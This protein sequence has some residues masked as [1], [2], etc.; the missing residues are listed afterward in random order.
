MTAALK[1]EKC[2]HSA[3]RCWIDCI[4]ELYC[5]VNLRSE[6]SAS[7]KAPP[8]HLK[9]SARSPGNY[10]MNR[11]VGMKR[12]RVAA[13]ALVFPIITGLAGIVLS[14]KSVVVFD[15]CL[16]VPKFS[17]MLCETVTSGLQQYT[18]SACTT[19]SITPAHTRFQCDA[20]IFYY[21]RQGRHL[22]VQ[23]RVPRHGCVRQE[24]GL[25]ANL[26]YESRFRRLSVSACAAASCILPFGARVT[27][28]A[29]R[30][31]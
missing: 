25:I 7:F 19:S 3:N 13:L 17:I 8:F 30:P 22:Q 20:R 9:R 28:A 11:S 12:P 18:R 31:L 4:Q 21:A 2:V 24:H 16:V 26:F 27:P 1:N 6:G 5:S 15:I 29:G 14:L 23:R 10:K